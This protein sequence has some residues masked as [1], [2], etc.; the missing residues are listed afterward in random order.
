[1]EKIFYYVEGI[2][3]EFYAQRNLE[4]INIKINET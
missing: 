4:S 3:A 1:M 2:Q